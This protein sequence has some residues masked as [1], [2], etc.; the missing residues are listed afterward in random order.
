M[1]KKLLEK[2]NVELLYDTNVFNVDKQND[3][4]LVSTSNE[5]YKSKKL[6]I[7]TGGLS[8]PK[9]GSNGDGYK[10]AKKFNH[11][12]KTQFAIGVGI[13]LTNNQFKELQGLSIN[14]SVTILI[15]NKVVIKESGPMM[16]SHFGL[17]GPIIRRV[18]GYISLGLKDNLPTEIKIEFLSLPEIEAEFMQMN[19]KNSFLQ[20]NQKLKNILLDEINIKKDLDLNN[21]NKIQ[22]EEIKKQ[23]NSYSIKNIEL[24][25][26]S[27]AIATGGGVH[28]KEINPNS[29]ESLIVPNLFFIGEVLD[30]NAKTNGFNLTVAFASANK[31]IKYIQSNLQNQK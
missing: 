16:F 25:D 23:F 21:M 15:N 14:V 3:L 17:G 13:K 9:T 20:I 6:I 11:T 26:I 18:S 7:A 24:L 12:I 30:V 29:F 1:E 10:I 22:K 4:F 31:C 2:D 27:Q 28:T 8:Y 19:I 5:E